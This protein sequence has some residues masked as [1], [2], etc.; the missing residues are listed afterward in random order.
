MRKNKRAARHKVDSEICRI[1]EISQAGAERLKTGEGMHRSQCIW[2]GCGEDGHPPANACVRGGCF[3][4]FRCESLRKVCRGAFTSET[5]R[6]RVGWGKHPQH[7]Q[8]LKG[9]SKVGGTEALLEDGWGLVT[10]REAGIVGREN[11]EDEEPDDWG[12]W[13]GLGQGQEEEE[14]H[15]GGV[16]RIR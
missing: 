7:G 15:G 11:E 5:A 10:D 14:L 2:K 9:W 4:T 8:T 6:K 12:L 16:P 3:Y 13:M 1:K